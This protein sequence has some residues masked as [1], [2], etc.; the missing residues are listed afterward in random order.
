MSPADKYREEL[1][2]AIYWM[3]YEQES[4]S[5][6]YKIACAELDRVGCFQR[7]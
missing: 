4:D 5:W 1:A 6:Q 2:E 7:G 3:Y